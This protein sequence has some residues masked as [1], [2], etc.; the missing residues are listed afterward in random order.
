MNG[1][2][3]A[4]RLN[5]F[6]RRLAEIP[7][8]KTAS[9]VGMTVETIR[10]LKALSAVLDTAVALAFSE[11]LVVVMEIRGKRSA[12]GT[13]LA[14]HSFSQQCGFRTSS[15]PVRRGGWPGQCV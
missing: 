1:I 2:R 5:G 7:P 9:G 8:F 13:G 6:C 14:G 11:S 12:F 15:R 4:K 10:S 3:G